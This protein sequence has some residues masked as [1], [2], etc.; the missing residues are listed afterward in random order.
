MGSSATAIIERQ[1]VQ[2]QKRPARSAKIG[3]LMIAQKRPDGVYYRHELNSEG[4][5]YNFTSTH[6][7]KKF[8]VRLK[9][10]QE[11]NRLG[12]VSQVL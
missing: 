4:S 6:L 5:K 11:V 9:Y 3:F 10:Q 8:R 7:Q 2:G 12:I 1:F